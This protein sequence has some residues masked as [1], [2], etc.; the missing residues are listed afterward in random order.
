MSNIVYRV[1]DVNP[2]RS[3]SSISGSPLTSDEIDGNFKVLNDDIA[4]K[5]SIASPSLTGIPTAPTA[6]VDTNTTQ[7]ASTA[8]VVSQISSDAP[9]KDGSSATPGSIWPIS[10]AGNSA[11]AN[12][13]TL[14]H[15]CDGNS[16]TATTASRISSTNDLSSSDVVYPLWTTNIGASYSVK[17]SSSKLNFIP[18]TGTLS[19]TVVTASTV[20]S[21]VSE[22]ST[23]KV[24]GTAVIN[25]SRQLINTDVSGSAGA[26]TGLKTLQGVSLFGTGDVNALQ[27][28]YTISAAQLN[29]AILAPGMY[30][31]SS[32]LPNS[33]NSATYISGW[34]H[35]LVFKHGDNNGFAAQIAVELSSSGRMSNAAYIR[36][37]EGA[38]WNEWSPLGQQRLVDTNTNYNANINEHVYTTGGAG[39]VIY[40]NNSPVPGDKITVTNL[41]EGV[42]VSGNGIKIHRLAENMTIDYAHTTTVFC[43]ID[44][45]NGWTV[46]SSV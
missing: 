40:L 44:S 11:T 5:A 17:A 38:T 20:N 19:A 21:A 12:T 39:S 13:A 18:S 2:N 10:I 3:S 45:T 36:T 6:V 4:L 30:T 24:S 31:I 15:T 22:T 25:S 27:S 35:V 33:T 26:N 28:T 23:F 41:Y 37:S 16:L 9:T 32:G 14:A 29:S 46:I 8:F 34:W 7:I 42:I 43:Y 1:S